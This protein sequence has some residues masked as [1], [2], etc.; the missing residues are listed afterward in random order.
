[1]EVHPFAVDHLR[2][3]EGGLQGGW[4]SATK[5]DWS[6]DGPQNSPK[7][8]SVKFEVVKVEELRHWE[9]SLS[10]NLRFGQTVFSCF[11]HHFKPNHL[12]SS[13]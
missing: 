12:S 11:E 10:K 3:L 6:G 4:N 7:Q 9:E 8:G 2:S 13:A 1:M 5:M